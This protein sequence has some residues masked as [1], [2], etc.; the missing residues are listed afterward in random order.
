MNFDKTKTASIALILMLT[1]SA[2]ILALPIVSA[3]DPAWTVDT[4]SFI[5][6]SPNELGVGQTTTVVFWCDKIPPTAAGAYGDRWTFTVE[7]T[8]P[9]SSKQT[10][11]PFESD[12]VG[13]GYCFFTPD[14]QG[15][16]SFVAMM[17][18]H[19]VDN[20]ASRGLIHPNP[21]FGLAYI[22]DTFK[23]STSEPVTLTVKQEPISQWPA[24]EL[25]TDYWDRPIE[26]QNREWWTISG[27]WFSANGY[28]AT[29]QGYY[30][31]GGGF[32]PY[33]VG[34]TSSHIVW[35]KPFEMF[36]GVMGGELSMDGG[37]G[38]YYNG[39]SYEQA[40]APPV[41]IQGRLYYNTPPSA[42]P[43]YGTH[44]V[45]LRTGE[46]IWYQNITI[47]YG[48]VYNYVSPNQFGGIP[49]LW[50]IDGSTYKM[51]DAYTGNWIL[52]LVNASRGTVAFAQDGSMLVYMYNGARNWFAMWNSS[53]AI[54]ANMPNLWSGN[55]YWLWRPPQGGTLDW[56]LGIQWNV[57]VPDVAGS[58]SLTKVN[59]EVALCRTV[60][61]VEDG[62]RIAE[63]VAYSVKE[64]E[65]GTVLWGPFNR[66]DVS[67][68]GLGSNTAGGM[69]IVSDG[70]YV[71]YKGETMEWTGYNLYTGA[72]LWGPTK[73]TSNAYAMYGGWRT[74]FGA[75]GKI[76]Q[77][78]M[79]GC[80][81][82]L[83]IKTGNKLW[84]FETGSSGFET[85]WGNWALISGGFLG[86]A[87]GTGGLK[88]YVVGGHTHLQ[89]MYRGAE[90]YCIDGETGELLWNIDGWYQA[91]APVG[92]DGYLATVNGYDMQL[93]VYGKGQTETTATV[94][95]DVIPI[96]DSVLIKGKVTDQSPGAADTPA[97][98]DEYMSD[99][100]EYVYMQKPMPT[101]AEG[102]E[103]ILTTLDPN[104]N[105][106]EIGRATS[107]AS[108][109]YGCAFTPPVPG[110]YKIIATFEGSN[111]YFGSYAE[112]YVNVGEAPTAG[113]SIEPEPTT[114]APTEPTAEAPFIT[115]EIAIIVAVVVACIIGV[116]AF[117]ALRKRK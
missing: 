9:D 85:T 114:P 115:T 48:Q 97:V 91:G 20:G 7:V 34:P 49:Y 39:M 112:T 103:V 59:S 101:D 2:T 19:L 108:G 107:S 29:S 45:D 81:H 90:L 83:D 80:V 74:L 27:N 21:V 116:V 110:L 117:W 71:D 51:Y 106:Y 5:T 58:L 32:N 11:G 60:F 3:H 86:G 54:W 15:T 6:L 113:G 52:D 14:Q 104:G 31:K 79:D 4:L 35:T 72:K 87:P 47:D 95:D 12:P 16:Y 13:T 43:N 82:C 76:Y 44:C 28:N 1:F 8:K 40:F 68:Q 77:V 93:Y 36:G 56:Q 111:A 98:A 50:D 37:V 105:S 30:Y 96:G 67:Y 22:G 73:S 100:M 25:P 75:Y 69:C 92:A 63:D 61:L 46:E 94:Q 18:E 89:P 42:K 109:V 23:A 33:T 84:T 41:I 78:G 102:V 17:D 10:L 38:G 65:E 64:G 66:T 62:K 24:A 55:N 26:G 53:L 57:T 88:L 99:W 70:V